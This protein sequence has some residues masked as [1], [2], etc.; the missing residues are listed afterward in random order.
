M[1]NPSALPEWYENRKRVKEIESMPIGTPWWNAL[2]SFSKKLDADY[3]L[4]DFNAAGLPHP[5]AILIY[6]NK[7]YSLLKIE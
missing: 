2:L 4:A 1:P 3:I 6:H 7:F 5:G